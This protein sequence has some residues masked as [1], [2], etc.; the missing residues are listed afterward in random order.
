M[1]QTAA[2][3]Q[4]RTKS[5]STGDRN[6]GWLFVAILVAIS[7]VVVI[8]YLTIAMTL[9]RGFDW[10]D[11]GFVYAMISS[12]RISDGE[13]WGFQHLLHPLY[14]FFGESVL[15]FR[16]L[17]L[18]AYVLLS[19]ALCAIAR[20]ILR[21]IGLTLR[22][23]S[24]VLIVLVA[25]VGTF[26]AWSYPPR[27]LGYNELSSWAAQLGGALL[28]LALVRTRTPQRSA[29][30]SRIPLWSIWAAVGVLLA[31]LFFA[32]I[33]SAILLFILAMV[34]LVLSGKRGGRLKNLGSLLGGAV[35]ALL[36]MLAFGVPVVAYTKSI[37]ALLMN[38]AAQAESGYSLTDLLPVYLQSASLTIG[39]LAVPIVLASIALI[40]SQGLGKGQTGK[41]P[42]SRTILSIE[43]VAFA[44]TMLLA[45]LLILPNN[46]STW[47]H[48]G[49]ANTFL[50]CLAIIAFAILLRMPPRADA[51]A[52]RP[53]VTV[54]IAAVLFALVPLVNGVGTNNPIFGQT[55]FSATLWAVGAA[56]TICLLW[57]QSHSRSASIRTLPVLLLGVAVATSGLA[58]AAD[59]FSHPYR[60]RPYFEQTT[61]VG[62]GDLR[63]IKLLAS[64]AELFEWIHDAGIRQEAE[65]VPTLSIASP[66]ALLAFN[67]SG[68]TNI[69]PGPDWASSIARSCETNPPKDLFVLQA[70][71]TTED[72]EDYQKLVSGLESCGIS[73]PE[74]FS[75]V[76]ER[77]DPHPVS[78]LSV[79]RLK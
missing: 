38:P 40:V 20:E 4:T 41:G 23:S 47:N 45:M 43:N 62:T 2:E 71:S 31:L 9:N 50:F 19:L 63:G 14:S 53:G 11:E 35:L 32:K 34:V 56:T 70:G 18:L 76:E 79:W 33:T 7:G 25:Q 37:S 67:S 72:A 66:G 5:S 51:R 8:T 13:F 44:L 26:A 21:A 54:G 6:P 64:E 17:R 59:V 48:I 74:D 1:Q 73:F 15:A 39:A 68:W 29:A 75:I 78:S 10:T 46:Q 69:W 65:G 3:V 49:I 30:H 52:P 61:V 77:K 28:L 42:A 27:Y 16:V 12:N 58:V 22:R 60:T 36:L 57:E 55:V 24:W